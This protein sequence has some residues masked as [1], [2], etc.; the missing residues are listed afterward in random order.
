MSFD[1]PSA[2]NADDAEAS[3]P[4]PRGSLSRA[5]AAH[6]D[7]RAMDDTNPYEAA[8]AANI[9]KNRAIMLAL[10]LVPADARENEK[11]SA[12]ISNKRATARPAS[13]KE[14]P[15][16]RSATLAEEP[17]RSTRRRRTV[18]TRDELDA[19]ADAR[20]EAETVEDE[21]LER[22]HARAASEHA[23]R[24]AGVQ[25]RAAIVGTASYQHTL[26]RVRTMSE[27]ALARRVRAIE[28]AKGKHAVVKMRLFARVL[29]L[30]GMEELAGEAVDALERLID[31][32]GDPE[33][34]EIALAAE[35]AARKSAA[36][37]ASGS[38]GAWHCSAKTNLEDPSVYADVVRIEA[39]AEQSDKSNVTGGKNIQ[40][41]NRWQAAAA[42]LAGA[43]GTLRGSGNVVTFD[44]RDGTYH[45]ERATPE[46]R[47]AIKMARKR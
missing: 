22:A 45:V 5:P 18:S 31:E 29:F 17:R 12:K 33:E 42:S 2:S 21:E 28:N 40:N 25:G 37:R 11:T 16:A 35:D 43:D 39:K 26:M 41:V 32:L 46:M 1:H 7:A 3:R 24:N 38:G 13:T 20:E 6:V 36:A 44:E 23:A 34:E 19:D 10:G 4:R 14:T 47:R 15:K 27:D 9:A 30:E 8:R